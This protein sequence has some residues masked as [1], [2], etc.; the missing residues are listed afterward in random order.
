MKKINLS[1]FLERFI[2]KYKL[3]KELK[4]LKALLAKELAI[5]RKMENQNNLVLSSDQGLKRTEPVPRELRLYV[6]INRKQDIVIPDEK[7]LLIASYDLDGASDKARGL[8]YQPV[9][10]IKMMGFI[11]FS[12]V[13][14]IAEDVGCDQAGLKDTAIEE[15]QDKEKL[16][17]EQFKQRLL[18]SVDMFCPDEDKQTL[19]SII[20]RLHIKVA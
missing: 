8:V 3:K 2:T 16:S 13:L 14:K 4:K 6:V 1:T 10:S 9:S 20:K 7:V 17:L 15:P 18:M 5:K 12:N 19:E 11:P